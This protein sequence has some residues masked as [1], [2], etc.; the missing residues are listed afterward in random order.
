MKSRFQIFLVSLLVMLL[1]VLAG[2]STAQDVEA[3]YIIENFDEMPPPMPVTDEGVYDIFNILLLGS[4][5]ENPRNSGRTDVVV[6]VSINRTTN[7]IAMLSLPRDF[8]VFIPGQRVYRINSAYGYGQQTEQGGA[9]LIKETIA[10][11]L[12][13]TIDR[14]ARVDFASFRRIVDSLGGIEISVDCR[15]E[16]WR[17]LEPDLDPAIEENWERFLLPVGFHHMD[18]NLALWYA[19][20][21]RTTNDFDRGRRHQALLRAM[22]RQIQNLGLIGQ[23]P[24]LWSQVAEAVDT[25]LTLEDIIGILPVA[26]HLD[27]SHIRS[28]TM[29]QNHE[30]ASW[31]SPEGSSVLAPNR[32]AIAELLEQFYSPPTIRRIVG[33]QPRIEIVN[34]SGYADLARVAADRLAWEGFIPTISTETTP[35]QEETTLIDF[36]GQSKGNSR[37]IL[38]GILRVEETAVYSEPLAERTADFRV[39][40]GGNYTACTYGFS[41]EE[42]P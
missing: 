38:Q 13:I 9:Q 20:S 21:R 17:L 30:V 42:A 7:T 24:E 15:I 1:L 10:Y 31:S 40:I 34:A 6:I 5:T 32:I 23:V 16:D 36:T 26:A 18:G 3:S 37:R 12:G 27:S 25:D 14:F 8:Y 19:R 22:W 35:F 11:N 29:R 28:F 41:T 39:T 33:E 2:R 4:D